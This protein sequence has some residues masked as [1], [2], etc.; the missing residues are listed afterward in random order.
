MER[1]INHVELMTLKVMIKT[2]EQ[3][4]KMNDK[5]NNDSQVIYLK[6]YQETK[7]VA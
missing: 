5:T 1:M 2:V 6:D 4:K 7:K 3:S